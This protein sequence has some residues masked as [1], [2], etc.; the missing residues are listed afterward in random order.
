MR[1]EPALPQALARPGAIDISTPVSRLLKVPAAP[2]LRGLVHDISLYREHSGQPIR[3]VETAS[4]VVPLLI[5]F[6]EPFDIAL[7]RPPGSGD[8]FV[9]FTSGLCL[10]PVHISSAGA[11]SCLEITLTPLGARRFFGLPMS[12]LTER[13]VALDDLDD[14]SLVSLRA[15]LGEERDWHRRL[16]IAEAFVLD[17]M[18]A[19]SAISPA[20]AF[21]YRAIVES[22]GRIPV[23][24]LAERLDWSRK[25]LAQRFHAEIGMAPKAVARVA[26]FVA[27]QRLASAEPESGWA[28]IA[29]ASGFSDQ[30]HLV[31]EFRE[32]AGTTPAAWRAAA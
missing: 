27:T 7:G 14:R 24:R 28:E 2:E 19:A 15:R 32:L 23:A 4:L 17:R 10:K 5:G 21:A 12:E 25:H 31:R 20:A 16:A 8:G 3:Q 11:C 9:S 13:M 26:R 22:G 6:A 30:A 1:G 29:A 18:R